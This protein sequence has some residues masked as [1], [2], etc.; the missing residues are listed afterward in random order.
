MDYEVPPWDE[1]YAMC[2]ELALKVR[3]SGY[4]PELLVGVARGGWVPARVLSDLMPGVGLASMR[5]EF[6]EDVAKA[7][8]R[9][10]ITQPVSAEVRGRKVL[11]VDD[12][13]DTGESL[14]AA[15]EH[16][17]ARG[18]AEVRIATL[19]HKPHSKLVPDYY[20]RSTSAWIVYPHE[21]FEFM[22]ST[23]A[24]MRGEGKRL[25]E[26]VEFLAGVGLDR[27]LV[28]KFLEVEG[29]G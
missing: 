3:A 11:V 19:H 4:A 16:V 23:L 8:R 24:R 18:A 7:G 14:I 27:A 28:A 5:V 13:A 20:V 17:R 10:V 25:E 21:R 22:R 2:V 29:K 26:V 12:V 1:V 9:P 6:Y 15:C